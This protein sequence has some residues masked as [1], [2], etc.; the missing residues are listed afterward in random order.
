MKNE[1]INGWIDENET[2]SPLD[3][4]FSTLVPLLMTMMEE[5]IALPPEDYPRLPPPL[6]TVN[7]AQE[8][9]R[10]WVL[11]V[12]SDFL[13]ARRR[14]NTV[15]AGEVPLFNNICNKYTNNTRAPL[16]I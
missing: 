8:G 9:E 14:L 12:L 7:V 4:L 5:E 10:S 15:S 13:C 11:P 1:K 16:Y 3:E 2:V 6:T